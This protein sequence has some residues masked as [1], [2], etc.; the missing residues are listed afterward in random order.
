MFYFASF[1][2]L[3]KLGF[4]RR[5]QFHDILENCIRIWDK[6]NLRTIDFEKQSVFFFL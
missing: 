2:L 6:I 4:V 3:S 5:K 1:N